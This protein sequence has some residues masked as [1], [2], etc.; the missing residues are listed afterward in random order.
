MTIRWTAEKIE[1]LRRLYPVTTDDELTR[2]FATSIGT[3]RGVTHRY[4]IRRRERPSSQNTWTP[5][6]T[7]FLIENIGELSYAELANHFGLSETT[8][9]ITATKLGIQP[10]RTRRRWTD[11]R[12]NEFLTAYAT[13]PRAELAERY[14]L[15]ERSVVETASRFRARLA[16]GGSR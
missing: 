12:I 16:S 11:E 14:G 4:N 7:Q 15:S 8:V 1:E 5:D 9:R 6:R 2:H 10:D 3:I 13:T